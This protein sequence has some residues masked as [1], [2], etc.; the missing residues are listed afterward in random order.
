MISQ[1]LQS[2]RYV[3]RPNKESVMNTDLEGVLIDIYARTFDYF[4]L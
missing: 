4:R 1:I 2:Y 3:C